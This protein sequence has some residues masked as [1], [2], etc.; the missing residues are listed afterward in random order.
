ML[1]WRRGRRRVGTQAPAPLATPPA[2]RLATVGGRRWLTIHSAWSWGWEGG[3][4]AH[5]GAERTGRAGGVA[6]AALPALASA[7][8]APATAGGATQ[9]RRPPSFCQ[10]VAV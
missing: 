5:D 1:W 2:A 4:R 8:S 9:A 10:W 3:S 6:A 7:A